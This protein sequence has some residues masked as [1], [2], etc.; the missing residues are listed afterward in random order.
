[1]NELLFNPNMFFSQKLKK[2][3]SFKYPMLIILIKAL[4]TIGLSILLINYLKNSLSSG[5]NWAIS[6]G[7]LIGATGGL[8]MAFAH[9]F[10]LAGVFYITSSF[11]DSKGSFSRTLEFVGYGFL[12]LIFSSFANL[13]IMYQLLPSFDFSS[14]DSQLMIQNIN[15]ILLNNP[16]GYISQIIGI[17]CILLSAN[18]WIFALLHARNMSLKNAT[19]SICI[20]V[21]LYLIYQIYSLIGGLT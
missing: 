11:F 12:P 20:P 16:L 13:I 19:L 6:I 4:F 17:L 15:Q 5:A 3:I 1:M 14:Q 10:I 9:W 7:S 21:G 2:D 18:I 8:L